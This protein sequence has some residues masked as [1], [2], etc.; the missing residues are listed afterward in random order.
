M[1]RESAIRHPPSAIPR[2]SEA[3]ALALYF[4]CS[5]HELG[6]RAFAATQRLH[7]ED[8]RTYVVDRN[9]NYANWC[10]AKCIFCNFKADP[11]GMNSSRPELPAGYVLTFDQI[12]GKIQELIDIGGTQVL[13]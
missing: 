7:P 13:M 10:T 11:P 4:D 2:L 8:Y 5:I 12:G 1:P 3:E 6:R 9:I